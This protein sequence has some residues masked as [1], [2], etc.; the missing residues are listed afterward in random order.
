MNIFIATEKDIDKVSELFN[1]YR[2]FYGQEDNYEASRKFIAENFKNKHS[3]VFVLEE[4]GVFAAFVQLYTSYCPIALESYK[5]LSDLYVR[6][7]YRRKGYALA[8]MQH[9]IDYYKEKDVQR[10]TLETAIDNV[11]G[12]NLY[13]KLGY[14][15]E[16]D[17]FTY[18]KLL[19]PS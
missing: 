12:Q 9:V 14:Q 11:P 3:E 4:Q 19:K 1:L 17:F 15:K 16:V 18:H 2:I 6:K 8:I 10:L 7:K 13:K 5:I